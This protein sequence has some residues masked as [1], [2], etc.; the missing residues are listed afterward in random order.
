MTMTPSATGE[1]MTGAST[2]EYGVGEG[3]TRRYPQ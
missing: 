2:I 3:T 1:R